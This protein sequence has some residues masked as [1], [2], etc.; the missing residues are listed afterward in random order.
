MFAQEAQQGLQNTPAAAVSMINA[1]MII[2]GLSLAAENKQ[3]ALARLKL[4][5][6]ALAVGQWLSEM[7]TGGRK[8]S[9][10]SLV[11][12]G[13]HQVL[14]YLDP[15][16]FT[17]VTAALMFTPAVFLVLVIGPSPIV[18]MNGQPEIRAEMMNL[19]DMP[20]IALTIAYDF[21]ECGGW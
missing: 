9:G 10:G 21:S 6:A 15:A 4:R 11:P 17:P 7:Q 2:V 3:S 14:V 1:V 18:W 13:R 5:A 20:A 16:A 12:A 19:F 8:R